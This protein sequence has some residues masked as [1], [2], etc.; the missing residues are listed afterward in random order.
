[1]AASRDRAGRSY[2]LH[3]DLSLMKTLTRKILL[4]GASVCALAGSMVAD[5]H[6]SFAMFDHTKEVE[7]Q[8]ATV[9]DWQWT[10]PHT[11]L[12]LMV[13]NGTATP[14]KYSIEGGNPGQLRRLGY[15]KGTFTA[16]DKITVYISPLLS[17][18]KGGAL[19]RVKLK[20]G[21]LIGEQPS[22][23]APADGK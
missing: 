2:N 3:V 14:D 15:G 16:G 8:N 12:F 9:V 10:S 4:V 7:L 22:G 21:T 20:D 18:E 11:W 13:P 23:A 1:M 6:H 5:A 19:V 17:G